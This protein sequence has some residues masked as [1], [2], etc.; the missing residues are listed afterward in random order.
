MTSEQAS[1][2]SQSHWSRLCNFQSVISAVKVPTLDS[3]DDSMSESE[4]G[5]VK[6]FQREEC[7]LPDFFEEMMYEQD[8]ANSEAIAGFTHSMA[9]GDFAAL[10]ALA[11]VKSEFQHKGLSLNI[12][13][14][15]DCSRT[16]G[17]ETAE[18]D[19]T[20]SSS[21]VSLDRETEGK[22][23]KPK[24][25][26]MEKDPISTQRDRSTSPSLKMKAEWDLD[27]ILQKLTDER[28]MLEFDL[29][30]D[31][32]EVISPT[33]VSVENNTKKRQ[34]RI[35]EEL[36]ELSIRQSQ[37]WS[38]AQQVAPERTVI[39]VSR[40]KIPVRPPLVQKEVWHCENAPTVFVDLRAAE[41]NS[42]FNSMEHRSHP[43]ALQDLKRDSF[44]PNGPEYTG[45]SMLLRQLRYSKSVPHS[46]SPDNRIQQPLINGHK[47][48][49]VMPTSPDHRLRRLE[50]RA[51]ISQ[52]TPQTQE[53]GCCITE[54]DM[55]TEAPSTSSP[56][57][58]DK[59]QREKSPVEMIEKEKLEKEKKSRQRMQTQLE[60]M[61]P[62][63]SVSGRQPMAR[64][65]PVLFHL[66]VSYRPE[67]DTLPVS[68]E[69]E[70]LLLTIWLSSCGQTVTHAQHS[71][72][73]PACSLSQ[74]NIYHAFLVWLISL[75]SPFNVHHKPD[76]PF[77]VLGLQQMWREEGLALYACVSPRQAAAD[78]SPKIR[79]HKIKDSLRGTS[80]F[81][82]QMSLFLSHNTLQSATWWT[83]ELL[84]QLQGQL[85]P[86]NLDIP[87]V[88]LSSIA[89]LNPDPEAV[90]K[91]F[92]T[93]SGFFWQTVE[94]EEKLSPLS[95]DFFIDSETEVVPVVLFD[96]LLQNP[97]AFHHTLHLLL[98]T[99]LD[100]CGLRLLYPQSFALQSDFGRD[101]ASPSKAGEAQQVP[102]VL[103]MALRGPHALDLWS[104]I[105]GPCDPA[106]AR[107][108]DHNSLNA[109]YGQTKEKPLLYYSRTSGRILRD[110]SLWFGGRIL[111]KGNVKIGI[112]NPPRKRSCSPTEKCPIAH[113][114]NLCRPPA[115][116][117]ATTKGDIFLVASPA[118]PPYAYGDI[119]HTCCQR[120]FTIHGLRTLRLFAKRA[121]MMNMS[122]AQIS[123][124]C[125]HKLPAQAEEE[126]PQ[127]AL[128]GPRLH[129]LLLLLRRENA[130]HH[131]AALIQGLMNDMAEQGLL[132]VTRSNLCRSGDLD[133]TLCFHAAPYSDSLLQGLGGSLHTVPD[134]SSVILDMLPRQ[135]FSFDPEAE[136]VVLLTMSGSQTLQRA[137]HFLRQIIRPRSTYQEAVSG[138]GFEGFEVLGLKW[139]PNLSRLQAKEITPYE[140][141]ERLWQSNVEELTSNPALVC[142]LRRVQAFTTLA[143]AIKLL[144]PVT[145]KLQS[146]LIMSTTSEIAFRQAVLIFTDKELVSDAHS[147]PVLKYIAPPG[148]YCR[149][150]GGE[151]QRAQTESIYTYMLSGSPVLYTVLIVKPGSWSNNLGKILRKA[152]HQ[153][154]V[155]VGLKM[156][157]LTRED[158]LQI[159]P[160]EAKQDK[161]LCQEHCDYL[162]SAPCVVLCLKRMNAV[163]RLLELLG[164]EDPRV[165]K[166]RDQ[167]LWRAQYG[168]SALH[169]GMYASTSYPAAIQ[170]IKRFFPEGLLCD[171]LS[172]PVL[173]REK[174][175]RL[176]RDILFGG[177]FQRQTLK[178]Q[179]C[180]LGPMHHIGLPYTAALCQTTCLLF[181][182][183]SRQGTPPPYIQGLEQLTDRGF[184]VTGARLSAFDQSQAQAVAELY[185]IQ[186]SLSAQL[187]VVNKGPCLLI[188]AQ[189]DN[190][191][192]CFHSLM[193]SGN[194]QSGQKLTQAALSPHSQ[195]Q[196]NKILSFF[197][198]SLAP[199]SI[200]RIVSL[201]S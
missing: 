21:D 98:T 39:P 38:P 150:R 49:D 33:W 68:R 133:P 166:E 117:T 112:Q 25:A 128:L 142:A 93:S 115:L 80:S 113:E 174:V 79:K 194:L 190:A 84:H 9:E 57:P 59:I 54:Q 64:H 158:C 185:S 118:I 99:G 34:D 42:H 176:T 138:H 167:F 92:S 76:V 45:K 18:N 106:L 20:S 50:K 160:V 11:E 173:E 181:P 15:S 16:H 2:S 32:A 23:S 77:Q 154:F 124:F 13:E 175:S 141:G 182:A 48:T 192:T 74:A 60:A 198:D 101:F 75:V 161:G 187:K 55:K 188:A 91:V 62:Q 195:S 43:Q 145:G 61:R 30:E 36:L 27:L 63:N 56:N 184:H 163:L 24:S 85:F 155:L 197:F 67:L 12:K 29:A 46:D 147:R 143:H 96:M 53:K 88:R 137:G 149:T 193:A 107:L 19:H 139:L 6:I 191:I 116:L 130:G 114:T 104:N 126:E 152:D 168:S 164:P 86:V 10:D 178:N 134:P 35:M 52:S 40:Q 121:S 97:P 183:Q 131:T 136:Q 127:T 4:C 146:R 51:D 125:S 8:D 89:V 132:G 186:G 105:S 70:M 103:A 7:L 94:T 100:V 73:F 69:G 81:Y 177:G 179:T 78:P 58:S 108:T 189:R 17:G 151:D 82:Q 22:H 28:T 72:R 180:Q 171:H 144:I 172:S 71:S 65:T 148:I 109:I 110:I 165:C 129:C 120:G 102:P 31:T 14:A 47:H 199:D 170:D 111:N 90:D 156:L 135:P 169:N 196:A 123:V 201:A 95:P 162:T 87:A 119:I 26:W 157:N 66:E 200:H 122:S 159:I 44:M 41:A 37:A 140:V 153:K 3:D 1:S 5:E 83:E